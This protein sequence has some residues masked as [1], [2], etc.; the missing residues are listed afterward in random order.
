MPRTFL[1]LLAACCLAGCATAP[2]RAAPM[3]SRVVMSPV[4]PVIHKPP[5]MSASVSTANT[6]AE[7]SLK[8]GATYVAAFP[9][10]DRRAACLRLDYREG[11]AEF[12][13]CLEGDFPENPYFARR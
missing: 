9:E 12:A 10:A 8:P 7:A 4:Q 6:S 1:F 2:E 5:Q 11:T 3:S 13:R